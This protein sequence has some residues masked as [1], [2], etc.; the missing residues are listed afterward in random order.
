MSVFGVILVQLLDNADQNYSEYRHFSQSVTLSLFLLHIK[1]NVL[2][3]CL[4]NQTLSDYG[5]VGFVINCSESAKTV[6]PRKHKLRRS[7]LLLMGYCEKNPN[8]NYK[9]FKI[10]VSEEQVCLF[11]IDI[12]LSKLK[13]KLIQR[14]RR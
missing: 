12:E 9:C 7:S 14:S 2:F 3:C 6:N 10:I 13:E 4:L 5:H 1:S 8:F 11:E